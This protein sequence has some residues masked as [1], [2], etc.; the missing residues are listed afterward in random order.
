MKKNKLF[1]ALTAAVMALVTVFA[2]VGCGETKAELVDM[3]Q[4]Q[5]RVKYFTVATDRDFYI[6]ETYTVEL[7][8][9]GTYVC[10]I[11]MTEAQQKTA[12]FEYKSEA[13][14]IIN[15]LAVT[16]F[17]RTGTYELTKNDSLGTFSLKLGKAS[18][19][20]YATNAGGGHYPVVPAGEK[21]FFDSANA[22]DVAEFDTEWYGK[23]NEL[24]AL[25]GAEVTLTGDTATRM[26]DAGCM[27][28]DYKSPMFFTLLNRDDV[29]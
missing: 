17:T 12:N 9:D 14:N 28:F 10:A 8:S 3:Y 13:A 15:P 22:A 2:L 1:I 24:E 20:T 21:K 26:F 27:V 11:N 7:Y 29:Y 23:W 18:R 19:L 25:V 4:S 5:T 6:C 16:T